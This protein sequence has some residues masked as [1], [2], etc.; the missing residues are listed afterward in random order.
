MQL[1]PMTPEEHRRISKQLAHYE[2]TTPKEYGLYLQG[3]RK[4]RKKR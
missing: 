3:R 2:R 4:R 1:E